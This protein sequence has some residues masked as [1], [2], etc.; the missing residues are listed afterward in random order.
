MKVIFIGSVLFSEKLLNHIIKKKV[1]I[2]LI[3]TK[4][5]L[6]KNSDKFDLSPQPA[7]IEMIKSL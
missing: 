3:I 6:K 7:V 4:K 2:K 5:V 1:N